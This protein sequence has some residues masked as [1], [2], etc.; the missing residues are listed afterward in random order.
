MP[1]HSLGVSGTLVFFKGHPFKHDPREGKPAG[2]GLPK[3]IVC[4]AFGGRFL[5]PTSGPPGSGWGGDSLSICVSERPAG[6]L[7]GG[8]VQGYWLPC[9]EMEVRGA[10]TE[11]G[12]AKDQL[13]CFAISHHPVSTI[14][15]E[16]KGI[17]GACTDYTAGLY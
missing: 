5:V 1:F 4:V 10:G 8:W 13:V 7:I 14:S 9:S 16:S 15:S 11:W 3:G 2:P 6:V 12:I 17:H